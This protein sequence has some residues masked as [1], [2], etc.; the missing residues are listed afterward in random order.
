[1]IC[2]HATPN[3]LTLNAAISACEK[4]CLWQKSLQILF[5]PLVCNRLQSACK[6]GGLV[7]KHIRC[8]VDAELGAKDAG[9]ERSSH[10]GFL[11]RCHLGLL[12]GTP[13]A[14]DAPSF[15]RH[16]VCAYVCM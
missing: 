2:E 15:H 3:T 11:Q 14:M 8:G 10:W 1:M 13:V 7:R 9:D 16:M 4:S 5:G 12:S 6:S